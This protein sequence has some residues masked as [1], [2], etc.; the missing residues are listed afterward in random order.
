M[1]K[2]IEKLWDYLI[3]YLVCLMLV[4]ACWVGLEYILEGA[5][6]SSDVDGFVA[7]ILSAFITDKIIDMR[8]NKYE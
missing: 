1:I 6:H 8:G 2:I 7:I 3:D 5:V 4:T